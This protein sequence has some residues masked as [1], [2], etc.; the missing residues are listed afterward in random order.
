MKHT[1][2]YNQK[3]ESFLK[4]SLKGYTRFFRGILWLVAAVCL[5]G[6]TGFLIVYPLW[7]FASNYKNGYSLTALGFLFLVAVFFLVGRM[8][9]S[10]RLAGG[11]GLWLKTKFKV[12]LKRV[13]FIFL[14]AA[15]LYMVVFLFARGYIL[16]ASGAALVYFVVLG[17]VLAGRRNPV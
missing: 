13:L 4:R 17:A 5:V 9:A 10:I 8:K 15:A 11:F 12:F 2:S 14:A 3:P 1:D 7:Y 16:V 6:L